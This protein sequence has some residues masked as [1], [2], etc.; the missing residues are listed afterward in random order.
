MTS[1]DSINWA[2]ERE[3]TELTRND[4]DSWFETVVLYNEE[5]C[6]NCFHQVYNIEE[7]WWPRSVRLS[8]EKHLE[9]PRYDPIEKNTGR[10]YISSRMAASSQGTRV[11]K[12]GSVDFV[13]Y[14]RPLSTKPYMELA[15]QLSDLLAD[16]NIPHSEEVLLDKARAL[17][18]DEEVKQC[19][20]TLL[21]R[22]TSAAVKEQVQ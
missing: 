19:D 14:N 1:N 2:N 20:Q 6:D 5:V 12:C 9:N 10:D 18:E 16:Y 8:L 17:K 11:C 13:S 15:M 7:E 21:D 3:S 22:A 4:N